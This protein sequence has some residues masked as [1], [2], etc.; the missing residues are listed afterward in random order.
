MFEAVPFPDLGKCPSPLR[1]FPLL[2]S[3]N[4]PK[5]TGLLEILRLV[6]PEMILGNYECFP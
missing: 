3:L 5:W 4:E 1:C 2:V 6:L